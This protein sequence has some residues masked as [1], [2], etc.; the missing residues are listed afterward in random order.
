MSAPGSGASHLPGQSK[1]KGKAAASPNPFGSLANLNEMNQNF[2]RFPQALTGQPAPAPKKD[3]LADAD[4]SS[5]EDEQRD[6]DL[7]VDNKGIIV[8]SGRYHKAIAANE[9]IKYMGGKFR[10]TGLQYGKETAVISKHYDQHDAPDNKSI[11]FK[12]GNRLLRADK[13]NSAVVITPDVTVSEELTE[14]CS[15]GTFTSP[16]VFLEWQL[17]SQ[18]PGFKLRIATPQGVTPKREVTCCVPVAAM[19]RSETGEVECGIHFGQNPKIREEIYWLGSGSELQ[20]HAARDDLMLLEARVWH[21]STEAP[22][23]T[24]GPA[25]CAVSWQGISLRELA[26]LKDKIENGHGIADMVEGMVYLLTSSHHWQIFTRWDAEAAGAGWNLKEWVEKS[27]QLTARYGEMW[28]YQLQLNNRN[29]FQSVFANN[30]KLNK[31]EPPR[32]LVR[33]WL[34]ELTP[35]GQYVGRPKAHRIQSYTV[36][37]SSTVYSSARV[38]SLQL[39]LAVERNRQ[40]QT[41][42]LQSSFRTSDFDIVGAFHIHPSRPGVYVVDL[43]IPDGRLLNHDRT[44][45]VKADT[46]LDMTVRLLELARVRSGQDDMAT[47]VAA[48]TVSFEGI[49]TE[50]IFGSGTEVTAIVEGPPLDPYIDVVDGVELSV[51]VE[52]KDD[53]TPTDRH[54]AAIKEIEAGIERNKGVDFPQIILRAPRSIV[55]TDS[56]AREMTDDLKGKV[57]GVC[58]AFSLNGDQAEA[59]RNATESIS[60]VTAIWGPPGTG[61]SW[62]LAAIADAHIRVGKELG[63]ERRRPVLACAPTNIAVDALMSHFLKGTRNGTLH[64]SNLVIVRYKGSLLR[65]DRRQA[66]EDKDEEGDVDMADEGEELEEDAEDDAEVSDDESVA[67]EPALGARA[68]EKLVK[69]QERETRAERR[70][71]QRRAAKLREAVWDLADEVNPFQR[72][73]PHAEYGFY[74][75]RQKKIAEWADSEAHPMREA[76]RAYV[77]LKQR[78]RNSAAGVAKK[79]ERDLNRELTQAEDQVTAYFLQHCVDIAFCTNSSSVHGMLRDWY[80]PKVLLSDELATCSIPDGATPVGGFKEHIEHWT[81][82]GDHQQQK[83]VVSSIGRSEWSDILLKSLFEWTV[84]LKLIDSF[85]V[86][87]RIQHRMHPEL[88][89]P[90]SI[91]YKNDDGAALLQDHPSTSRQSA[92]WDRLE[93]FFSSCF[94]GACFNGRRRLCI[95]V[96]GLDDDGEPIRS[97]KQGTSFTNKYEADVVAQLIAGLLEYKATPDGPLPGRDLVQADFLVL[98]PYKAQCHLI[99]QKL[100]RNGV[101][102][103]GALVTCTSTRAIQ[104]GDGEI[105]I[106]SMARTNPDKANDMGFLAEDGLQCVANSRAKQALICVGNYLAWMQYQQDPTQGGRAKMGRYPMFD[107]DNGI[108]KKFGQLLGHIRGNGDIVAYE[109]YLTIVAGNRPKKNAAL[110]RLRTQ[111]GPTGIGIAGRA[112][113]S[114]FSV[115]DAQRNKKKAVKPPPPPPTKKTDNQPL[116]GVEPVPKPD[117]KRR[118]RGGKKKKKAAAEGSGAPAADEDQE[119]SDGGGDGDGD[120]QGGGGDGGPPGGDTGAAA[121]ATAS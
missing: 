16:I 91:W 46:K 70:E 25:P 9:Y 88:S 68:S 32:N 66:E 99:R 95:D 119:M 107:V 42:I 48:P 5:S 85:F 45:R 30:V 113:Q 29:R 36:T 51:K 83:P 80:R 13:E 14:P 55:E 26:E 43:R 120:G 118:R 117:G 7:L 71:E 21:N 3:L 74:V 111:A 57:L 100:F 44:L 82:A 34:I 31:L 38:M 75:Q 67:D 8:T 87:L 11:G 54:H 77:D 35:Q 56:L 15:M 59:V 114:F 96:S 101:N 12:R 37:K 112:P 72:G 61:K 4:S 50:D 105:V 76:A 108:F 17:N 116:E 121:T 6:G 49:V 94:G 98:S 78:K 104:G 47:L 63:G 102:T 62:N 2:V 20:Q 109:D 40:L 89:D 81:M 1:G 69:R 79:T 73:E 28:H 92:V 110:D 93:A 115:A 60:G 97:D 39:R 41:Q 64:G 24:T 52:L 53:P 90:L 22:F 103:K 65:R 33:D 18:N 58:K 27:I 19:Q 84:E 10:E 106:S 86:K 23:Y